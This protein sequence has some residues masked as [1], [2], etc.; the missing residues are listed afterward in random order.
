MWP[1]VWS[2]ALLGQHNDNDGEYY[3]PI[4]ICGSGTWESYVFIN[5]SD[6][7][8]GRDISVVAT[9]MKKQNNFAR[10]GE[11]ESKNDT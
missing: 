7:P 4:R 5:E 8:T 10:D 3:K 9:E 6:L 11:Q 2:G 1:P